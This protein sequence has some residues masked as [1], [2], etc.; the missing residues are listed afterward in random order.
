MTWHD[1]LFIA[2][3]SGWSRWTMSEPPADDDAQLME[4]VA[5]GD[6]E[7]FAV[8]VERHTPGA[9]RLAI[10]LV[11]DAPSAEDLVQEAF[12]RVLRAAPRYRPTAAFGTWLHRIVVNLAIDRSRRRAVRQD[13]G[14]GVERARAAV[15][16]PT[17]A[18]PEDLTRIEQAEQV[19]QALAALP[20]D[21]RAAVVLRYVEGMDARCMGT[22]LG[23]SPKAVER[24]LARARARLA[25]LLRHLV[26]D[27][28]SSRGMPDDG[29]LK[30]V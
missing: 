4:A 18:P 8:L 29:A 10:R 30:G 12:L 7:A 14:P 1:Q 11:P 28:P 24:L 13:P 6:A 9:W 21:Y 20:P 17:A 2:R 3:L 26:E 23:R 25:P 5:G 27:P 19:Q 16:A 22:V 15:A